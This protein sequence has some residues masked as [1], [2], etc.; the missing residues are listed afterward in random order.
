MN[1]PIGLEELLTKL[2]PLIVD[3]EVASRLGADRYEQV[4]PDLWLMATL[5]TPLAEG[6]VSLFN[7]ITPYVDVD[8]Y[9]SPNTFI[10]DEVPAVTKPL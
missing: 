6:D 5:T 1:Y 10:E 7:I 4:M 2:T 3:P 9:R 8:R